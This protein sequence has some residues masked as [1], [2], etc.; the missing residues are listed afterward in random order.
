[1]EHLE[2]L[3]SRGFAGAKT[4]PFRAQFR[5]SITHTD[6]AQ[7]W[8]KSMMEHSQC[9]YRVTRTYKPEMKRVLYRVDLRCQHKQK[10]LSL[11]QLASKSSRASQKGLASELRKKKT[12][13][14][15]TLIINIGNP[16]RKPIIQCHAQ[17]VLHPTV[18]KLLFDHYHPIHSAHCLSIRPITQHQRF[19][20]ELF[21]SG[22]S[23]ATAWHTSESKMLSSTS[24]LV[25]LAD[26][27]IM[28]PL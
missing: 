5:M 11:K 9:T 14:P 10:Q 2:T 18:V 24:M 26:R 20:F 1:M 6:G 15:S 13:C 25:D 21:C 8:L 4:Y 27:A 7:S 3:Q 28:Q 23:A 16:A 12:N 22:H 19:V 17:A